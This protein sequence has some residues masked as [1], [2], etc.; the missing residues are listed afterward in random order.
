M[1]RE[2]AG[3]VLATVVLAAEAVVD[4]HHRP[5][6][7][8]GATVYADGDIDDSADSEQ[9]S[10]DAAGAGA[11]LQ[12]DSWAADGAARQGAQHS[13]H[14][15]NKAKQLFRSEKLMPSRTTTTSTTLNETELIRVFGT[16]TTT[17]LP[18]ADHPK[19]WKDANGDYCFQ[20]EMGAFCTKQKDYGA[21]WRLK[22]GQFKDFAARG[23]VV[24][25]AG[26]TMRNTTCYSPAHSTGTY[27][28]DNECV[29]GGNMGSCDAVYSHC[30]AMHAKVATKKQMFKWFAAGEKAPTGKT[31][32][33]TST[34]KKSGKEHWMV[35]GSDDAELHENGCC[36]EAH[37]RFFV[38]VKEDYFDAQDACCACGGGTIPYIAATT[39]TTTIEIMLMASTTSTP[40]GAN[41]TAL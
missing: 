30:K 6:A 40:A 2:V 8:G 39:T 38:C 26:W 35:N 28:P 19:D 4:A 7:N 3:L 12:A 36:G 23:N 14:S 32:A 11:F 33:I 1:F 24:C 10:N 16:T 17:T 31:Y 25:P 13:R 5:P 15:Q 21:G 41:E 29:K 9:G 37:A 20:Y 34:F 22:S 27:S 18:C